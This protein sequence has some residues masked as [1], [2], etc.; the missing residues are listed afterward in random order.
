MKY[1][2]IWLSIICTVVFAL[3]QIY[4]ELTYELALSQKEFLQKP[5]QFFTNIFAHA[6]VKHLLYN[7][8]ALALFGSVLENL[9]SS[10][11][12]VLLFILALIFTNFAALIFYERTLGISGIVYAI[13][14]CLAVLK[15]R[16]PVFV[17]SVPMPLILAIV[18][19]IAIDLLGLFYPSQVA[20]ACHIAGAL[21]GFL[22]GV[23]E[24]IKIRKKRKE[25]RENI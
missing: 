2:A 17:F 14:A 24:K 8:F 12:F 13:L 11:R 22:F 9:I 23:N 7:I 10:K 6:N 4:P 1:I 20:S 21:A 15:P 3:Q 5:W 25:N 18:I 19:Y 16:L